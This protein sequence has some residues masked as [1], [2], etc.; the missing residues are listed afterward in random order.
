MENQEWRLRPLSKR[1][2]NK[3]TR[4]IIPRTM[5]ATVKGL[6]LTP[7]FHQGDNPREPRQIL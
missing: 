5:R 6:I 2:M 7:P 3:P 4:A 1:I